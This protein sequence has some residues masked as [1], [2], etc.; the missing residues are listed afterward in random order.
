MHRSEA[1]SQYQQVI[2]NV[3][4]DG[5]HIIFGGEVLPEG[6]LPSRNYVV[7][8]I[9]SVPAGASVL[10][11]EV[12]VPIL[13]TVRFETFEEAIAINNGVGQGLSSSLFT[14]NLQNL[15]KWAG[16]GSSIII[17]LELIDQMDLIVALPM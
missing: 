6:L 7:P 5:G 1:V 10:R 11:E 3:K 16:Y 4:K 15:F 13:H 9:T 2:E 12:F 8:T 17:D 14:R